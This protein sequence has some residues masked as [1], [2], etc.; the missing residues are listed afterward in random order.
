MKIEVLCASGCAKCSRELDDLRAAAWRA[1]PALEWKEL[2]I[3]AALDYAI[4]LGVLRPPAVAIDGVLVFA[5]LPT[6]EALAAAIHE[7]RR[8]VG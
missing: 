8:R 4:E 5:S 7:R 6:P 1:D 2:E 3:V